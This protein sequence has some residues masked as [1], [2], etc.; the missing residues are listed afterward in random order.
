MDVFSS[1]YTDNASSLKALLG[2]TAAYYPSG[3][4]DDPMVQT[5][6]GQYFKGSSLMQISPYTGE[7]ASLL[8]SHDM[9]V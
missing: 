3:D 2:S 5:Y 6:A 9:T 8:L 1:V 7:T 4:Q